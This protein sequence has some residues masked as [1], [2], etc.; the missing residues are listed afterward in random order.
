MRLEEPSFQKNLHGVESSPDSWMLMETLLP[1]SDLTKSTRRL[2]SNASL[3][4]QGWNPNAAPPKNWKLP[5][6]C[7]PA[8]SLKDYLPSKLSNMR[9][10]LFRHARGVVIH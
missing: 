6:K 3:R 2:R 1:S 7:R 5:S 10:S 9:G 4:L 8:F